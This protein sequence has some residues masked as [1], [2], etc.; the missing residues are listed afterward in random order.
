MNSRLLVAF[1]PLLLILVALAASIVIGPEN[2]DIRDRA[3]GPVTTT[4]PIGVG[5]DQLITLE[6][7]TPGNSTLQRFNLFLNGSLLPEAVYH[8][9]AVRVDLTS[10]SVLGL[11]S[12][13]AQAEPNLPDSVP[14]DRSSEIEGVVVANFERVRILAHPQLAP[15]VVFQAQ[16]DKHENQRG[17]ALIIT[18]QLINP[19]D[20]AVQNLLR[21]NPAVVT[22]EFDTNQLSEFV[23]AAITQRSL[24]GTT[25]QYS[26]PYELISSSAES[27]PTTGISVPSL[28]TPACTSLYN[29][30]CALDD[31][32]PRTFES[33]CEA[34]NAGASLLYQGRCRQPGQE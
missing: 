19:E 8:T 11:N 9:I 13:L 34:E 26:F 1:L 28:E 5:S 18:G 20:Q 6:E 32:I 33:A 31:T 16:I 29:P 10:A 14:L 30:V 12:T 2:L 7:A 15:E 25:P 23:T 17:Y 24:I 27:L 21:Q 3:A 4:A 22:I